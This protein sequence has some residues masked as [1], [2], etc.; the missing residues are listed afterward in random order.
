VSLAQQKLQQ[1]E[2]TFLQL[3]LEGPH[4][5]GELHIGIKPLNF[6]TPIEGALPPPFIANCLLAHTGTCCWPLP[7]GIQGDNLAEAAE[8]TSSV[9]VWKHQC[10]LLKKGA[11]FI[12]V[13]ITTDA[14]GACGEA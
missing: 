6:S 12:R 3:Q 1:G 13:S 5:K 10:H 11:T 14:L 7:L 4:A 8:D 9:G 2:E